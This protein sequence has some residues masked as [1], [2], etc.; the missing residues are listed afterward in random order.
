MVAIDVHALFDPEL[1]IPSAES[2]REL[3]FWIRLQEWIQDRRPRIGATTSEK[4]QDLITE[5]PSVI[6]LPMAEFWKIIGN[7]SSRVVDSS[8]HVRPIC[9]NHLR[10]AYSPHYGHSDNI[11]ALIDT[12]ERSSVEHG[13]ALATDSRCWSADLRVT[14]CV[15]CDVSFVTYTS[16][17][18]SLAHAWRRL[19]LNTGDQ[20]MG[21]LIDLAPKMFPDLIF[22]HSAWSH[23]DTLGGEPQTIA[24]RIVASLTALNDSVLEIW[25]LYQNTVDRQA[26]LRSSG[27]EASPES[28][29][30]RRS[31]S[32][33]TARRFTFNNT[34]VTCEWHTKLQP[35]R[36]RI[37]FAV[38]DGK[39]YVGAITKHL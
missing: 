7:L 27:I 19:Y 23:L 2:A 17:E 34:E 13:T 3:P 32:A 15:E 4:L 14:G 37:Y 1:I 22:S 16:P 10:Q 6:G 21:T 31:K 26:R 38:H 11:E 20:N 25:S 9:E 39:I 30:T 33:M 36:D 35:H 8:A 18:D 24:E 28:S 5:P 29:T 12:L